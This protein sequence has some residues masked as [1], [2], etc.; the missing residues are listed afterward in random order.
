MC[1]HVR[2]DKYTPWTHGIGQS[3]CLAESKIQVEFTHLYG[4][5]ISGLFPTHPILKILMSSNATSVLLYWIWKFQY[6]LTSIRFPFFCGFPFSKLYFSMVLCD[7]W[8]IS[9]L[10]LILFSMCKI[11]DFKMN[12]FSSESYSFCLVWGDNSSN[13]FNV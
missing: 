5:H 11:Y 13:S 3:K 8:F 10:G 9:S 12:N 1:L 4:S 7:D 2:L 6:V